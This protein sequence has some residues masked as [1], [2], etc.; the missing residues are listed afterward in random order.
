MTRTTAV[1]NDAALRE[2]WGQTEM[3][4]VV[5]KLDQL[6][7]ALVQID[8]ADRT[9]WTELSAQFERLG[10][11]L[12]G[13]D[14]G[15]PAQAA[16]GAA[17]LL[18]PC[19]AGE[20]TDAA[21]LLDVLNAGVDG[22]QRR[23]RD[24]RTPAEVTFPPELLTAAPAKP[25]DAQA[26]TLRPP[27]ELIPFDDHA[28]LGEPSASVA[29][30]SEPVPSPPASPTPSP[31]AA[32]RRSVANL[33]DRGMIGEFISEAHEHLEA[34]D[35]H[36]LTLEA[37][38]ANAE[39]LN[40]VFR[41]FH[42]LKGVAGFFQLE[43]IAVVAHE[44]E[45]VLDRARKGELVFRG[46]VSNVAFSA[47]D[48]LRRLIGRVTAAVEQGTPLFRDDDVPDLLQTIRDAAKSATGA[49]AAAPV[50]A[51]QTAA[52]VTPKSSDQ[53]VDATAARSPAADPAERPAPEAPRPAASGESA[54]ES[55][56]VDRERLDKLVDAIGEL[57]IA[58]SM[59]LQEFG[60]REDLQSAARKLLQVHKITRELQELSLAM[61]MVPLRNTL[62]KMARLVRDVAQKV[63]KEVEFVTEGEDVELDKSVIDRIN[64]P[65]VHL[66]RNSIDHGLEATGADRVKAGKPPK[67]RVTVRAFHQ[68]GNIYVQ[69]A[70]DGRG[71]DRQAILAKARE[72]GL[73]RDGET[74]SDREVHNLLFLPGFS[75]AKQVTDL[76]GRG[77][78]LDVVKRNIESLRGNIEIESA[79]GRGT[80]FSLRLPLTLA[81]IDGMVVRIGTGRFIVPTVSI[82][83]LLRP[84]RADVS[85]VVGQG[86]VLR[87]RDRLLPLFR[88]ADLLGLP[89]A[90]RNP[91]EATVVIV[92]EEQRQTALVVD[93][94][95]GQQQVVI[96]NLGASLEGTPGLV[97]GAILPD[98]RV[99]LI[100]DVR[101]LGR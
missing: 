40:A 60:G 10:E 99:G 32:P 93:E 96:K 52:S 20:T 34:A 14:E 86:E 22:L 54:K 100:V 41:V 81:I 23:F 95:V 46:A 77:V 73:I 33:E 83:E 91:A 79:P 12:A 53:S 4:E 49:G 24:G 48:M 64:D 30:P 87:V 27:E 58:E 39:S 42:T 56:R 89:D 8:P 5:G 31:P 6:A 37:D 92:E 17:R 97:G 44:A 43:D 55:V 68:S 57:V 13:L 74:L 62:Q 47:T 3:N 71:L 45:N 75:T 29:P 18:A 90:L 88:L 38:P 78:G 7:S 61:R 70:D 25:Q 16:F 65:L 9:G 72:R 82:V 67:G 66:L 28:P 35:V 2:C 98:G 101:N 63:R 19:L 11:L 50:A 94:I 15:P 59:V 69:I 26:A 85:T 76:S 84:N 80:T 1:A 21:R 36:L 51:G